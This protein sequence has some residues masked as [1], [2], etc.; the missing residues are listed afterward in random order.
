MTTTELKDFQSKL[1]NR[2]KEELHPDD[3]PFCRCSHF[4]RLIG[5]SLEFDSCC[6]LFMREANR[7]KNE[8]LCEYV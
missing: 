5:V 1:R 6:C 4:V 3:C 7:I 2:I 8:L